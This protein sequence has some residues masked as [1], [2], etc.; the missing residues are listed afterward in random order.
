VRRRRRTEASDPSVG[1]AD[2]E[3]ARW[4]CVAPLLQQT[5]CGWLAASEQRRGGCSDTLAAHSLV[6]VRL[7]HQWTALHC[8]TCYRR[9]VPYESEATEAAGDNA[10]QGEK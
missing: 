8:C 7:I 9:R 5:V 4:C 2:G 3:G 1:D 10:H 6:L